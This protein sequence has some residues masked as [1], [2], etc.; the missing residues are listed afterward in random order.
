[1]SN[2]SPNP[3]DFRA[4]LKTLSSIPTNGRSHR[5]DLEVAL[6]E[7]TGRDHAI[8]IASSEQAIPLVLKAMGMSSSKRI[9][10]PALG[11][12]VILRAAHTMQLRID[13]AECD[14]GTLDPTAESIAPH[15]HTETGVALISHGDGWGTGF[16]GALLMS[17]QNE[18]PLIELVGT[19]LGGQCSGAPFG[20]LGRAS[21]VDLSSESPVSGGEGAAILTDD[22]RLAESCRSLLCGDSNPHFHADPMPEV[23][24]ALALC[25]IQRL[26]T[27]LATYTDLAQ[28]YTL[29]LSRLPELL[30]PS[31]T[32]DSVPN[33]SSYVVRLDET[34]SADDRNHI[35]DGM[36]RHDINAVAGPAHLPSLMD[37]TATHV[38]PISASMA[39]RTISLPIHE[40]MTRQ[41][42]DLISQTLQLMIQR[43]TF[44][45]SA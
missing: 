22:V 36:Q 19:R 16:P 42:I 35:V 34:F 2:A 30:L 6:A 14:P 26:S 41:D 17:A 15:L 33:W 25:R 9:I 31:S 44:R 13:Y 43:A 1:M 23:V 12:P 29:S 40:A 39:A 21:I 8:A 32:A 27:T 28:Q 20:S 38:C 18:I 10:V 3:E 5:H 11:D 7:S 45:R 37:P 4:L 24:A